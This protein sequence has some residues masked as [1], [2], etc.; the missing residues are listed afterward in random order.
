M[1]DKIQL[2][3]LSVEEIQSSKNRYENFLASNK[4]I[5]VDKY[6]NFKSNNPIEKKLNN[7]FSLNLK[8]IKKY[9][10]YNRMYKI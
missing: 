8:Q 3:E 2:I 10:E 7:S 6:E 4:F 1:N 9:N 5:S